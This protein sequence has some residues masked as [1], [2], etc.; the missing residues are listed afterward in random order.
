MQRC[1]KCGKESRNVHGGLCVSCAQYKRK[2]GK[3]YPLPAYGTVEYNEE[4]KPICHICGMAM[5]KLIEHTK[6]K[7]G[8]E[9]LEYREMFGL[10]R[11]E[12]SLVSPK[13]ADKMRG[14]SDKYKS[15]WEKNFSPLHEG[16][17]PVGKRKDHRFTE[18]E[19]QARSSA[20]SYIS[21]QRPCCK[22]KASQESQSC[23][24]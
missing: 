20:Q 22:A 12:A 21:R 6:R 24:K 8:L 3:W 15:V 1:S 16:K 4:G 14:Y 9:S 23:Q 2:G 18:Q 5:D 13:Y 17:I 11:K 7:H 19:K 10:M